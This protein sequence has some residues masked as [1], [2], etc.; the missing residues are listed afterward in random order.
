MFRA[1]VESPRVRRRPNRNRSRRPGGVVRAAQMK[2]PRRQDWNERPS[3]WDDSRP[4]RRV[5]ETRPRETSEPNTA[6]LLLLVTVLIA[7]L[8]WML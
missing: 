5:L 1:R 6:A 3:S 2:I 8:V 7:V 4:D